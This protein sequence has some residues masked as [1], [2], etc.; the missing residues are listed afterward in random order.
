MDQGMGQNRK[1]SMKKGNI[2]VITTE[3]QTLMEIDCVIAGMIF[4]H[5]LHNYKM[6]KCCHVEEFWLLI[7]SI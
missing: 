3:D 1:R 6:Q 5:A 7:D 2:G 4:C